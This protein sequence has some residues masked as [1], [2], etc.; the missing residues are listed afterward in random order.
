MEARSYNYHTEKQSKSGDSRAPADKRVNEIS[1]ETTSHRIQS[2]DFRLSSLAQDGEVFISRFNRVT[3]DSPGIAG[4]H[5][6]VELV[7]QPVL[8]EHTFHADSRDP[9]LGREDHGVTD[10]GTPVGG[11]LFHRAGSR[12]LVRSR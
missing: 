3:C 10:Q 11:N 9:F 5:D 2:C 8:P 12:G 6:H 1:N 4:I 7:G